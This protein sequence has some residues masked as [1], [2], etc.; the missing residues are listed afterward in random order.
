MNKALWL[1]VGLLL[2]SGL[3]L[4]EKSVEATFH[5][6]VDS[7]VCARVMLGPVTDKRV[8]CSKDT[9]KKGSPPVVV[10][11]VDN[12][13]LTVTNDKTV[14]KMVGD[15]AKVSGALKVKSGKIKIASAEPVERSAIPA[16]EIDTAMMDVRN[17]KTS[18]DRVYEQVR[19][20][21]AMMPYISNFDFISF[22]I[23]GDEVILTGW[24]VRITNRKE[25]YR[26][27][28]QID[29]RQCQRQRR[30]YRTIDERRI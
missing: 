24:T 19:H 1:C 27:V 9:A 15:F 22:A 14:K 13:V 8:E 6:Y 29:V 10:R 28:K 21:L 20:T 30:R 3:G 16:S 11:T 12:A 4:A 17:Y 5:A 23:A 2:G 7:D 18:G 26:R 25:A